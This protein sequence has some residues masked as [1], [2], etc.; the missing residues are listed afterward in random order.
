MVHGI[1]GGN[2]HSRRHLGNLYH[3]RAKHDHYVLCECCD[4]YGERGLRK[5]PHSRYRN[6]DLKLE[7]ANR[8]RRYYYRLRRRLRH[9]NCHWRSGGRNLWVVHNCNRRH[10]HT[11][12]YLGLLYHTGAE[13]DHHLLRKHFHKRG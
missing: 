13:C 10:P 12:H 6:P 3:A 9:T 11:R 4:Q 8:N 2:A 5:H 7:R 1:L